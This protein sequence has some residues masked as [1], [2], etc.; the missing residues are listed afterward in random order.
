MPCR[1]Y[2]EGEELSIANA[3]LDSATKLLCEAVGVIQ[4]AS[5]LLECSPELIAWAAAHEATDAK[6]K[7]AEASAEARA[8]MARQQVEERDRLLKTLTAD[9]K[10]LLGLDKIFPGKP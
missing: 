8:A 3:D 9:Q 10:R 5:K 4:K 1:Y 6:R 7:K 2:S